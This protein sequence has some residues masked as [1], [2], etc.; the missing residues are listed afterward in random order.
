M[1]MLTGI[2][3]YFAHRANKSLML[4]ALLLALSLVL[5]SVVRAES[6]PYSAVTT[7]GRG[8]IATVHP[9]ATQ[10]AIDAFNH[11]G[12]AVD[13][14]IAAAFTLGV[15]DGHNSGIGGGCFAV[16]R[17]ADGTVLAVDGRE[18]APAAAYRDMYVRDGKVDTQ[19][20]KTGPLAVGIPGSVATFEYLSQHGGKLKLKD[21]VLPAADLA[22]HGFTIDHN[23]AARLSRTA[24][25]LRAFPD[26]A[27][28][29][30]DSQGQPWPQGHLLVQKDLAHTYRGIAKDG[31]DY[32]YRGEF[33]AAVGKWMA[34][35]GGLITAEDFAQYQLK[36]REPVVSQYRGYTLYGFP[37]PSSGGVHVAEILNIV[38]S[39]D[40]ATMAPADRYHVLA[41]AMKLAFADRAYWLGD[42]DFVP[43]PRGLIDKEYGRELAARIQLDKAI[44]VKQHGTPPRADE[45]LF[46][47]HT[48]HI[49][50]ADKDG[51]WVAITTT[52][53][54]SFGS[55]IIVPGTGVILN[56][57]MDDFSSQP[58]T[59][60]AFRLVGAEANS[61]QPKKRPLSSMSPT[62]IVKDGKPV[63]TVG[64][65]GGPT[66]ITQ[67]VQA[68][69]NH[70]DLGLPLQESL[71]APRI[72]HQWNPDLLFVEPTM[73]A[74]VQKSLEQ[75][76]HHI[77]LRSGG[78][79]QAI[80]IGADGKFVTQSEPRIIRLNAQ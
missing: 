41:E 64:A 62:I 5:A 26:S 10:A 78:S 29:L 42:P 46:G 7:D 18:M 30:L 75:R 72:H 9:L 70:L 54:T 65:A 69:V 32:Y 1:V 67:V 63:M 51:N 11:G 15:V 74:D 73:P 34:H 53:N 66:I 20:S 80:A 55:K 77:Q 8:A 76:G 22:E 40:L 4:G 58:G 68:V 50:A 27:A 12:N 47:K 43:V 79:S 13:A 19:L 6:K 25:S 36:T 45:D 49:A 38:E 21:V 35:N 39:F 3:N 71:G 17:L 57:Q 52:V 28:I 23:Y 31:A 60:N 44:A 56:N 2:R 14:A 48:T 61:I 24:A 59:P 33:S 16:V 37:P